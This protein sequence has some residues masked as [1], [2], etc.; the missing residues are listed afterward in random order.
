MLAKIQKWGNS[1]G[2]RIP[3]QLVKY[4]N[5]KEGSNVEVISSNKSLIITLNEDPLDSLLDE[6]NPSNLHREQ[7]IDDSNKGNESW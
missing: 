2:L 1:L 6:I 3:K 5:L 4:I 7:L